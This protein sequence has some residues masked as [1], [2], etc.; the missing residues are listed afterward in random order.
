M[1][2]NKKFLKISIFDFLYYFQLI[3][4]DGD[5]DQLIQVYIKSKKRIDDLKILFYS[6][7]ILEGLE[8]VHKNHKIHRDIKPK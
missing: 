7:Q 6:Q 5:L 3:I 8:F 1:L 2:T 4:K